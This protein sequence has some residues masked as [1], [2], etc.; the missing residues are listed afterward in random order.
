MEY[1]SFAGL[2]NM[3]ECLGGILNALGASAVLQFRLER[4]LLSVYDEF[5]YE[6]V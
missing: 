2:E 1:K 6:P 3:F 5:F 4:N